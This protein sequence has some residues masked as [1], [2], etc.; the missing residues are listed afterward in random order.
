MTNTGKD[1]F[2]SHFNHFFTRWRAHR[3]CHNYPGGSS[4]TVCK[5]NY[6]SLTLRS[7]EI[8]LVCIKINRYNPEGD[9]TMTRFRIL[10]WIH[11][12]ILVVS[13][14]NR[15]DTFPGYDTNNPVA[16]GELSALKE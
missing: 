3:W 9:G 14:S 2:F 15:N 12:L 13:T 7:T 10:K 11:T 8:L 5:T 6:F 16:A 4:G 1:S